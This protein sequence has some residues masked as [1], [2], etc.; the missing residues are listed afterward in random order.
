MVIIGV[1]YF[2]PM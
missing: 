1:N 2:K